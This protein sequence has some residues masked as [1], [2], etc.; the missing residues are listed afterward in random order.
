MNVGM[1]PYFKVLKKF[2]ICKYS[3]VSEG[4]WVATAGSDL[5]FIPKYELEMCEPTEEDML[6]LLNEKAQ[7]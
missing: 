1:E 4:I 3:D 5:M 2:R 7:G 6:R